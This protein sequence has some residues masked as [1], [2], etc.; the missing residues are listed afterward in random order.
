M[1]VPL[2]LHG[3]HHPTVTY[4]LFGPWIV[5]WRFASFEDDY[6]TLRAAVGLLDYST[7]AV[8]EVRGADRTSFLHR[9]LTNDIARLAPGMGCRTA[10][11]NP[12]AKL[13][14]DL[15]LLADPDSTWLICDLRCAAL[16][17]QTLER[18]VFSEQVSIINHERRISALAL[19]GPRTMEALTRLL[20]AVVSLPDAG[21]HAIIPLDG[22]PVR[23]IRHTLTGDVGVLALVSAE[24]AAAA[25]RLL[26]ERG[27]TVGVRPAGWEALN[28]AR[29]EAGAPWFG[30]DMDE[31][32]LLPETGLE[33]AAAS[34]T[35]GCYVGQEIVARL[36]TYGS[37]NKR[38]MGVLMEGDQQAQPGDRIVRDET[39]VGVVTSSCVSPAL[40]CPIAMGYIKRGA[41]EPGTRVEVVHG[42]TR[43]SATISL[44][45]F[46][47]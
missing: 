34:E 22:L 10:L 39:E 8:L 25:W 43:L 20:G 33:T 30:T 47:R 27:G 16:A 9:L 31:T 35:K 19:Q 14:A 4:E 45:P 15:L 38:L 29:I 42:G 18:Y 3:Q 28:T 13:I 21:D 36:R 44:L 23:W 17:T 5:P 41:C 11:L 26:K 6:R 37:A 2:L 24:D 12:S 32:N 1:P 46:I 7:Q 40:G